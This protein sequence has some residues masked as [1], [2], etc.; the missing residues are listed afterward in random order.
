MRLTN[1]DVEWLESIHPSLQYHRQEQRITGE[2]DFCASYDILSGKMQIEGVER[3]DSIRESNRAICDVFE[4]EIR[5]DPKSTDPKNG[6]P[7]VYEVGGRLKAIAEKRAIERADLHLYE[8]GAACLGIRYSQERNLTLL[9]FLH[10][11]VIPF[12]Y[13]LSYVDRFGL[14][15]ARRDLW[16][17]YSHGDHGTREH[18][19]EMMDIARRN[20]GKNKPCPC[21][22]GMKYKKCCMDEVQAVIRPDMDKRALQSKLGFG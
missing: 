12:F 21:G 10:D 17:E 1:D 14:E 19:Q 8:D 11:L 20:T 18:E 13:R 15:A 9:R 4:I 5:L 7:I 16:G 3:D 22:N 2:L 6:W